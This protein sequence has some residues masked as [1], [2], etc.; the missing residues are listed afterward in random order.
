MCRGGGIVWLLLF[1]KYFYYACV[2]TLNPSLCMWYPFTFHAEQMPPLWVVVG[3]CPGLSRLCSSTAGATDWIIHSQRLYCEVLVSLCFSHWW[4]MKTN[5]PLT[6]QLSVKN[7]NRFVF[8]CVK[9]CSVCNVGVHNLILMARDIFCC[10][11]NSIFSLE[12]VTHIRFV[13]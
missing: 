3:Y 7:C 5:N 12:N 2:G 11:Y 10:D 9:M 8:E 4:I 13:R 6:G 1:K